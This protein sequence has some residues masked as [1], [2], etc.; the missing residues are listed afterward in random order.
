MA[1]DYFGIQES[2]AAV[3]RD[4]V[5]EFK[6]VLIEA[7]DKEMTL[8]A[9]PLCNVRLVSGDQT[10]RSLPNGLLSGAAVRS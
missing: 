4:N 7:M 10:V 6:N 2:L 5:E 9:M 1:I 3:I 8:D